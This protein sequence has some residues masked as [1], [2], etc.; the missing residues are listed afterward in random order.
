MRRLLAALLINL[1]AGGAVAE[2]QML[3]TADKWVEYIEQLAQEE[4][5]SG[6]IEALYDELSYLAE[7]PFD[8]NT[9]TEEELKRLPFISG[10]QAED[11]LAYRS[12]YGRMLSLY[13]LNSVESLDIQSVELLLPF[14]Y[15]GEYVDEGM[16]LT[17][18]NFLK[19]AKHE[20]LLR[21][22]QCLQSKSG[23]EKPAA[24]GL[25][26]T[27]VNKHYSGEP[28]YN[29]IRYSCNFDGRLQAGIAGE[30]DKGEPFLNRNHKG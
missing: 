22:D 14:I 5:N 21:Y 28:F 3:H 8:I 29:S 4:E 9:V 23:Y 10:E 26:S 12:R 1:L 27:S 15:I 24:E 19:Y 11:L 7:H 13:E 6:R 18:G 20:L 2:A 16:K 17:A 25:G 30:K